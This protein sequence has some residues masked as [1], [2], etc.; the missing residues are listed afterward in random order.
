VKKGKVIAVGGCLILRN[1]CV[2]TKDEERERVEKV[3]VTMAPSNFVDLISIYLILIASLHFT[4][5]ECT[6][7]SVV[8]CNK[9]VTYFLSMFLF[10]ILLKKHKLILGFLTRQ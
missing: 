7:I 1:N 9:C 4:C 6:Y 8:T 5:E 3:E 2:K 10:L